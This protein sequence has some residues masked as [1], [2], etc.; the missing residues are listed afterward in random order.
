[1]RESHRQLLLEGQGT[2]SGLQVSNTI[3]AGRIRYSLTG[4]MF[5]PS[6]FSPNAD[7]PSEAE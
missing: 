7:Y 5:P 1:M 2:M 6:P 3:H 4:K